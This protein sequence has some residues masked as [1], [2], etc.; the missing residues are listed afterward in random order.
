MKKK[1]RKI[2]GIHYKIPNCSWCKRWFNL[3]GWIPWK[4]YLTFERREQ[5]L[6][7]LRK[8]NRGKNFFEYRRSEEIINER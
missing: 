5:A 7:M 4:R 3:S 8:H 2:W 1:K 6:A